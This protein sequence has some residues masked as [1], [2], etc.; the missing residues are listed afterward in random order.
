MDE[1]DKVVNLQPKVGGQDPY[2]GGIEF[3]IG[4]TTKT[5]NYINI[6]SCVCTCTI[7]SRERQSMRC[8]QVFFNG[9]TRCFKVVKRK[10]D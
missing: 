5:Y 8:V 2:L 10:G 9:E 3:Y 1:H 6:C 7:E 4:F